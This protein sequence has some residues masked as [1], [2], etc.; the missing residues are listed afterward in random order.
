M[1]RMGSFED[2]DRWESCRNGDYPSKCATEVTIQ[3]RYRPNDQ[4]VR[5]A[6][7]TSANIAQVF[8]RRH[9]VMPS[10]TQQL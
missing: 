2:L 10:Y 7:S 5:A 9:W 4:L 1:A 6:R 8:G 3:E